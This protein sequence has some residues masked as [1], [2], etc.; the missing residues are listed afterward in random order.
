MEALPCRGPWSPPGGPNALGLVS[1]ALLPPQ[2][3]LG[4]IYDGARRAAGRTAGTSA[5][6]GC[7]QKRIAGNTWGSSGSSI[8]GAVSLHSRLESGGSR[9]KLRRRVE[10]ARRQGI[11]ARTVWGTIWMQQIMSL[12]EAKGDFNA[13]FNMTTAD[14]VPWIEA[15]GTIEK[16]AS[17]SPPRIH[18]SHLPWNY[19]PKELRQKK[20]KDLRSSVK[21][22]CTFLDRKLSDEEIDNVEEH[23]QFHIMK[24]NS[25]ANYRDVCP[26]IFD[27]DK[28]SFMRKG[29]VGDW[30][31]HLTVEQNQKFDEVFQ[32]KMRDVN[33]KFIWSN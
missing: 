24:N 29:I 32:E 4:K 11:V 18:V 3:V 25:C 26:E 19:M 7:G 5:T 10:A 2:E 8:K 12:I 33:I 22:I 1:P 15:N 31:K 16:F 20:G 21:K 23:S 13:T 27:H 30:K 28:G 14:R 9:T 17:L 6:L